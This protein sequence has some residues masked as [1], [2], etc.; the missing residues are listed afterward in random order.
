MEVSMRI[1]ASA[2]S[3]PLLAV[4]SWAQTGELQKPGEIQK[5]KGTWQVPGQIQKP[6]D[7][8]KVKEQCRS[9]FLV[10]SDTLFDFDKS[11]LTP[12]AEKV[13]SSL[14]PM[15]QKEGQHPISI[16]G[17]TDSLGGDSYN[18]ALSERRARAVEDWLTAHGFLKASA[19]SIQGY[20]KNKP[21]APNTKPDGSDNPEG[22][23][24]NRRVEIVVDTCKTT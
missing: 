6:G 14:G 23:Q 7:I 12:A 10:A 13:L 16:E 22:R 4:T 17:Y 18:Q 1:R 11:D 19:T 8:Q 20:G 9:R 15:I 24:K 21:L 2:I 3:I 5:P